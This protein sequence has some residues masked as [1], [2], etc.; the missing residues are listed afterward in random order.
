M[1]QSVSRHHSPRSHGFDPRPIR[2]IYGGQSDTGI[3]F[4]PVGFPM[5]VSFHRC[6]TDILCY[7]S[8]ADCTILTFD[9][10]VST[11]FEPT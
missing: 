1:A 6:Y 8:V 4:P 2:G 9:S 3:G 10:V 5:S 7:S 11:I